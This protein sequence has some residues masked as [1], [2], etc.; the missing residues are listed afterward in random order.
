MNDRCEYLQKVLHEEVPLSETIGMGVHSYDGERLELRANLEPNVNIYGVA[1]GGSIYSMCALSGWGLL[2]LQLEN[3]GLDPRIMITGGKI[4]Y[5]KPVDQTI[6]A[7]SRL[8]GVEG[9]AEFKDTLKETGK[10]R[11]KVPVGIEL[12]DGAEAAR[13][14]GDYIALEQ[15]G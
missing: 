10:A 13:F 11:I 7:V 12:D 3:A 14:V 8:S 4:S 15:R 6:N 2:I 9:F 5:F 1:F